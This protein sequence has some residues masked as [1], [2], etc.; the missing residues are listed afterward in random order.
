[1]RLETLLIWCFP[2][3]VACGGETSSSSDAGVDGAASDGG[4]GDAGDP[5]PTLTGWSEFVPVPSSGARDA[6]DT[7]SRIAYVSAASGSDSTGEYYWWDGTNV[8]DAAGVS[9]GSDPFAPT[10]VV[11]PFATSGGHAR[12]GDRYDADRFPDWVLF[13]RGEDYTTG[14]FGFVGRSAQEPALFG[15]YGDVELERPRI[16]NSL[17][18]CYCGNPRVAYLAVVSLQLAPAGQ[19]VSIHTQSN[20][21]VTPPE[22]I[23]SWFW[24]EDIL[25]KNT[26]YGVSI[27]SSSLPEGSSD[28]T[29][30]RSVFTEIWDPSAHNQGVYVSGDYSTLHIEDSIFYRNGFKT[31]PATTPGRRDIFS[32]NF[33]VGGGGR[34]GTTLRN[35]ISADGGSGGPQLRFGGR[36]EG[37]LIIEG[38]W[39]AATDSNGNSPDWLTPTSGQ[40]FAIRDNVQLVME[41]PYAGQSAG[42]S[43]ERAHTGSGFTIQGGSSNGVFENNIIS[44]AL[45]DEAG[46]VGGADQ[47]FGNSGVA[48]L[49]EVYRTDTGVD[50]WP[51]DN[52][53]R[54]N[55]F[56]RTSG[57]VVGGTNTGWEN[58]GSNVFENNAW[59]GRASS[60]AVSGRGVSDV[61]GGLVLRGNTFYT[62]RPDV[63]AGGS[64]DASI[65]NAT[66]QNNTVLPTAAATWMAPQRTLKT[67][68]ADVLAL[69]VSSTDGM[70]EF[71]QRAT[72]M[73]KGKWYEEYTARAV[74]NYIREG[75]GVA[76]LAAE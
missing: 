60:N 21:L 3:L 27:Q 54:N 10:G 39:F 35:V 11:K 13:H 66:V 67:Y 2:V 73:R 34:L 65:L 20:E 17:A 5:V 51:H 71:F 15:A 22:K 72:Q 16:L 48:L 53:I 30:Y 56:Y 59:L 9:Y 31:D 23:R 7:G 76:P 38:Y 25:V 58:A 32:R 75:F 74:V 8:V 12:G 37:S 44:G 36:V 62:D 14:N 40:T 41:F 47:G 4:G 57:I 19:A 52:T 33:Y 69:Q 24:F 26:T 43:D 45:L 64:I 50:I 46:F 1:M 42:D 70:P 29:I 49:A 18:W 61:S 6:S 55:I 63:F 68:T 28:V